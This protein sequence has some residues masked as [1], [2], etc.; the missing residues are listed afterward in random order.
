MTR[1]PQANFST[2]DYD[3]RDRRQVSLRELPKE[4]F[5]H[6]QWGSGKGASKGF[7]P[8]YTSTKLEVWQNVVKGRT[9]S[10]LT[11]KCHGGFQILRGFWKV[12]SISTS[13]CMV[14][15]NG[16]TMQQQPDQVSGAARPHEEK[17]H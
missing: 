4:V 11:F 9:K 17:Q 14:T 3:P 5:Q 1:G 16:C 6:A 7:P 8:T 13:P 12:I 10:P 15:D 2:E